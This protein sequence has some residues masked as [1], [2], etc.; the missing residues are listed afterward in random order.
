VLSFHGNFTSSKNNAELHLT[1]HHTEALDSIDDGFDDTLVSD[2]LRI[3]N[4][5]RKT[6]RADKKL[7]AEGQIPSADQ[8]LLPAS[9]PPASEET[10]R[11]K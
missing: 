6:P 4:L 5:T 8:Q 1:A 7:D 2:L 3:H 11:A 9:K 10:A